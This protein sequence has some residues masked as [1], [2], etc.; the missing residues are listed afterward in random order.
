METMEGKFSVITIPNG[1]FMVNTYLVCNNENGN[2]LLVDPGDESGIIRNAIQKAG[3]G[4]T[5]IVA[6][7]GHIDHVYSAREFCEQ[8][9][10]PLLV[11]K[12]DESLLRGLSIQSS[13]FGLP[14]VELPDSIVYLHQEK[15]LPVRD[16]PAEILPVPGHT[17]G[18]LALLFEDKLLS[19]DTLFYESIGRTDLPGGSM[20]EILHSIKT[21]LFRLEENTVVYPGHGETTTIGHEKTHNPFIQHPDL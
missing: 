21:E 14:R 1:I 12:K 18:S 11:S 20:E 6:T 15:T 9:G 7:H 4:I 5:G 16:F 13:L 17:P 19:G 3:G 2:L 10:L 8:Y